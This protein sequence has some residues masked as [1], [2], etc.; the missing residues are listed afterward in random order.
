MDLP[1]PLNS[2]LQVPLIVNQ[3]IISYLVFGEARNWERG[4]FS[5]EMIERAKAKA[6]NVEDYLE[7]KYSQAS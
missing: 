5:K 2:A 6:S 1:E 7:R 4:P 3:K